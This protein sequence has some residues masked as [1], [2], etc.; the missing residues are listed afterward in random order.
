MFYVHESLRTSVKSLRKYC[1]KKK[2]DNI[3]ISSI[4]GFLVKATLS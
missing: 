1:H 3:V 4:N 2:D